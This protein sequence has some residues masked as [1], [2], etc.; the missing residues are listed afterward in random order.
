MKARY[1]IPSVAAAALLLLGGACSTA[2]DKTAAGG[3]DLARTPENTTPTAAPTA[4]PG[5]GSPSATPELGPA[6]LI[7]GNI[8]AISP[9]YA[10][11][12]KQ[13]D[14]RSPNPQQPRGVCADVNFTDLPENF[15]WFRMAFDNAEVTQKLVL[16]ASSA[17]APEDGRICYAPTEGFTVGRH[18]V[19]VS[20]QS[21]RDT[22]A[23][24]R[25]I[26][27]WAFDVVQ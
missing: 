24:T 25:Q 21:P 7:A 12:V 15:Q 9:K 3:A 4:P 6:P 20:V 19:A 18:T 27:S 13:V 17:Q 5:S 1:L 10:A 11:K 16:I 14:T 8:T 2:S 22:S 23:P 26:V